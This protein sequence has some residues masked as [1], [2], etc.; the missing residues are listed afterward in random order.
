[1]TTIYLLNRSPHKILEDKTP[2]ESFTGQKPQVNHMRTFGCLVFIH[3]P[4]DKT[5]KL[6]PSGKNGIFFGYNES[7]K[8]YRSY[9]LR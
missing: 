5:N 9:V 1:M 4:K 6:E 7:S 3:V 8:A 2:K